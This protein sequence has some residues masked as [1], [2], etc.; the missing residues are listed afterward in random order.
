MLHRA[1]KNYRTPALHLQDIVIL[2]DACLRERAKKG[3]S[4]AG[5][6]LRQFRENQLLNLAPHRR[7]VVHARVGYAKGLLVPRHAGERNGPVAIAELEIADDLCLPWV[8]RAYWSAAVDEDPIA[9][10]VNELP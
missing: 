10:M 2:S 8:F 1:S 5:R 7:I 4:A 6:I 3:E 9:I